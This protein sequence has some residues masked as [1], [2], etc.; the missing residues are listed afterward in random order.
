MQ[1]LLGELHQ[2]APT[3]FKELSPL[4][5]LDAEDD[6]KVFRVYKKIRKTGEAGH[7]QFGEGLHTVMQ[8][9]Y[10]ILSAIGCQ[11]F[12]PEKGGVY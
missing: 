9:C 6:E 1:R 12:L 10:P 8:A 5:R 2:V 7:C 11:S 4:L 3:S